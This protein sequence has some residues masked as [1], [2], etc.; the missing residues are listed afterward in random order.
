M[1]HKRRK[2]KSFLRRLLWTLLGILLFMGI[3]VA[4]FI[5]EPKWLQVGGLDRWIPSSTAQLTSGENQTSTKE[6]LPDVST[7]DWNLILVNREYLTESIPP[8]LTTVED[9]Q[10]DSRIEQATKDFLAAIRK[11]EP[12]EAILSGYRSKAEQAEL[13]NE[14]VSETQTANEI[15]HKEAESEVRKHI[16]L[17]GASEHQT[18]LAIDISVPSGQSDEVAEK[19]AV[20]APQYG[21]ILRYPKDKS[22]VT[23]VDFENWHYR[24]VG[25]ESATYMQ[26]HGLALEE[27]ITQLKNARK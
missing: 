17:P 21:F 4:I 23:G 3:G 2:K 15:S 9:I 5:F 19:I 25:V 6:Q 24:Y 26:K 18:G 20:I 7:S 14:A 11:F 16:Q 12:E 22:D 27:Y 1:K 13:F 8:K 10:L